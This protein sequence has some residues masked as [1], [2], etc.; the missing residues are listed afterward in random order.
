MHYSIITYSL[1]SFLI[2]IL[3]AKISY[4]LR[5]V[6]LPD[7]RKIHSIATAYTGGVALSIC[8]LFSILLF[9]ITS[10]NLNLILSIAFLICIIGFIDD[11]FNLSAGS[12]LSLQIL[13]IF[14]L[15][16]LQNLTLNNLGD[17]NYFELKLGSFAIPFTLLSVLFLINAFNY[18]D[19]IDGTLSFTCISVLA[20][21][22]FL[23]SDQEFRFFLLIILMPICIFLCFNFSFF[24]L[25]KLFLGDSG[26]LLLGFIVS[27][28]LIYLAYQ[29]LTHPI[30]LAWSI[31]IYA[32]EFIS[33]NLI[34]L[35]NNRNPF[36]AGR[37]HLHHIFFNK[38]NSIF[39]TNFFITS[40]NIALFAI[41]YITFLLINSFT[42]LFL[43]ISLFFIF[44]SLRIRLSK[45][46]LAK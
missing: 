2:L 27:F 35:I 34:R 22:Y 5:L 1:I 12:K 29:N 8:F 43:F 41:G 3:C 44:F 32:Y 19:G 30:L 46:T 33:I 42:S 20:I 40:I 14:Y 9:Q 26:S 28:I 36:K 25:P 16:I 24:K 45:I 13:P 37:D 15:I 31:V 39:L 11:K 21:L 10:N 7:E 18:F 4:R 38:T 6:D 23:I 17:Y